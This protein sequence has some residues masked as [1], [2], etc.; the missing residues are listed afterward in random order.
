MREIA[1]SSTLII[2]H[3]PALFRTTRHDDALN[4]HLLVHVK[5]KIDMA[6]HS[7]W[8]KSTT[9]MLP[10]SPNTQFVSYRL[11][12]TSKDLPQRQIIIC[13]II[14]Q[15]PLSRSRRSTR[16]TAVSYKS[17]SRLQES[18]IT[19][20]STTRHNKPLFTY[21]TGRLSH[22]QIEIFYKDVTRLPTYN[23]ILFPY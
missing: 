6:L 7:V 5:R 9:L 23:G 15:K 14:A 13:I 22:S 2:Q 12:L 18:R 8:A 21:H 10:Y 3:Q 20:T 4:L 17:Y 1:A 16:Q 11:A 19:Y